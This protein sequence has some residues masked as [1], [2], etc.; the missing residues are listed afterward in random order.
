MTTL[1]EFIEATTPDYGPQVQRGME[2]LD[3][4]NPGWLAKIK[5][6]LLNVGDSDFCVLAQAYGDYGEGLWRL[7][8]DGD[9]AHYGFD[10]TR[11]WMTLPCH[12]HC[13][14]TD[15]FTG[16]RTAASR[17]WVAKLQE[18]WHVAIIVRWHESPEYQA[19]LESWKQHL[20]SVAA[21]TNQ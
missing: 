18:T 16:V 6:E 3:E 20:A 8:A 14:T 15:D 12:P 4:K 19:Y 9:E 17:A 1:A 11:D 10:I 5:L 7:G 2:L 21:R 13:P